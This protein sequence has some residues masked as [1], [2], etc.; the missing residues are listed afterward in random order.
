MKKKLLIATDNFLP[1]WDGIGRFLLEIVPKLSD[2]YDITIVAPGFKGY[3]P[4]GYEI[5]NA[6]VHRFDTF[7]F[8]IGDFPPAKLPLKK[9]KR[10]VGDA[11]IVWIQ[12]I[13]PIGYAAAKWA[14]KMDRAL[15]SFNHSIEWE[16]VSSAIT[17][18]RFLNGLIKLIVKGIARNVYNKCDLLMVPSKDTADRLESIG[19]RK[20]MK[21]VSLG[22]DINKFKPAENKYK[23]KEAVG[24]DPNKIVIGYVGRLGKEKD[25]LTLYRAFVQLS[26]KYNNIILLVVGSG[27]ESYKKLF[28]RKNMI[29]TGDRTD[30]ENF[31]RA[32]DIYVL[33]SLT[34]T[35]S[36][37]TMEAMASGCAVLTTRVGA[38]PSYV[39]DRF[40]GMFFREK[41]SYV[42]RK[43]LEMLIDNGELRRKMG[44]NA[45]HTIEAQHSWDKT[46]EEIKEILKIY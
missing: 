44:M 21:Q 28:S 22:I 12:T 4:A 10:F 39:V 41:N 25:L 14:K 5:G 45:R 19:I 24:I 26:Y 37:T 43:K 17:R 36:L 9:I 33:P 29:Y 40:N 42:L 15:I 7:N 6:T 32:I 31:Y 11:D 34:E 20:K 2:D 1:R 8:K 13:G 38:I 35:T 3:H 16:L 46:V 27:I 23:A 30:V 18:F